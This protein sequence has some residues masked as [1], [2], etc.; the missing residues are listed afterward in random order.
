MSNTQKPKKMLVLS[1][2]ILSIAILALIL[3]KKIGASLTDYHMDY[4]MTYRT[5]C[6]S[7]EGEYSEAY[8]KYRAEVDKVR[9]HQSLYESNFIIYAFLLSA[10]LISELISAITILLTKK[11]KRLIRNIAVISTL[12]LILHTV[13]ST[14]LIVGEITVL[15]IIM[16][17]LLFV[18]NTVDY[19]VISRG[20]LKKYTGILN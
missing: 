6:V 17:A 18:L 10:S 5:I 16:I 1:G 8:K 9:E 12:L 7:A 15:E 13:I 3:S 19:F 11:K 2:F 4:V 20:F 14:I